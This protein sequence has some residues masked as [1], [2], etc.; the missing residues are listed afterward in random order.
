MGDRYPAK[1]EEA[2]RH[3]NRDQRRTRSVLVV[4]NGE[5]LFEYEM[6]PF[7]S[8][9]TAV[10]YRALLDLTINFKVR[11]SNGQDFRDWRADSE[12]WLR[13]D[14]EDEFSCR[15]ICSELG[16]DPQMLGL[17]VKEIRGGRKFRLR[18]SN[19]ERV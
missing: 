19:R 7:R 10:L 1:L 5:S 3:E 2:V 4:G 12:A 8:L 16:I 11:K 9:W 14:C 18:A 13:S 15:W 17:M 6:R